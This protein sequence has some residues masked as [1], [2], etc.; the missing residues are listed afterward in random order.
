MMFI[1]E[2][3]RHLLSLNEFMTAYSISILQADVNCD[4]V[5]EC[6][7]PPQDLHEILELKVA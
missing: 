5:K 3:C 4:Y 1:S 6:L 2:V 7:V